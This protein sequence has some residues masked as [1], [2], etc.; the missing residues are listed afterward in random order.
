MLS[1][2]GKSFDFA[3][4]FEIFYRGPE[5]PEIQT[6]MQIKNFRRSVRKFWRLQISQKVNLLCKD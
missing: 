5:L 3:I 2:Q 6:T 1:G 4:F